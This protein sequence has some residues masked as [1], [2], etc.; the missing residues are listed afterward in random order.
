MAAEYLAKKKADIAAGK[1]DLNRPG[2]G[3]D[4][5]ELIQKWLK[6]L[7]NRNAKDDRQRVEKHVLPAFKTNKIDQVSLPLILKWIDRQRAK[8]ELSDSSI[9]HNLN[10]LSRFFSW[11]IERGHTTVNPVKMIPTSRRPQETQK[12]DTPWLEDEDQVSAIIKALPKPVGLMF[13]VGNRSG[14]RT[15]EICGL[16]M[17]DL[18]FLDQGAIRVRFSYDGPL[19]EDKRG[20]GK[21]KWVPAAEDA[22]A[23]LKSWLTKRRSAGAK[24]EDFVFP[25]PEGWDNPKESWKVHLGRIWN[26]IATAQK[27]DLTWYECTRH[28]FVS[29]S[30][31]RGASLDEVSSAVGHSSPAV[32][33]RYYDHFLRKTFSPVLRG[34][35]PPKAAAAPS[36]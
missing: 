25:A 15:G 30:L 4:C 32:T 36:K 23:V 11:A 27:I 14:L 22:S 29:R 12:R 20:D 7:A 24:S 26:E 19:K 2:I 18:A 28:S 34:V 17:A 8:G 10:L 35:L 1:I 6:G 33:R 5:G 13:Y 3:G 21:I 31:S 9:R 16:R